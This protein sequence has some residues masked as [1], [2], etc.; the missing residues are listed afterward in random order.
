MTNLVK[1]SHDSTLT[2]PR[3][4]LPILE[5]LPL[6]RMFSLRESGVESLPLLDKVATNLV[7]LELMISRHTISFADC[8]PWCPRTISI[9]EQGAIDSACAHGP[10][11]AAF[12]NALTEN[13]ARFL[14][15]ARDNIGTLSLDI[16]RIQWDQYHPN[17]FSQ[18]LDR[19]NAL[20]QS[21]VTFPRLKRLLVENSCFEPNQLRQLLATSPFLTHLSIF[22]IRKSEFDIVVKKQPLL[23]RL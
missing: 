11:E 13:L 9:L 16:A 19:A 7:S 8:L 1:Y 22:G 18:V 15:S 4:F 12:D 3:H 17:W 23:K 21:T 5:N 10:T 2:I 20:S 6:L 14:Y